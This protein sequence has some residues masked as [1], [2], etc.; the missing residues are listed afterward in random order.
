MISELD[1][2]K[3]VGTKKIELIDSEIEIV[4]GDAALNFHII[5]EFDDENSSYDFKNPPE[6]DDLDLLET[7]ESELLE[8]LMD[9]LMSEEEENEE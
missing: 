4:H 7:S 6:S 8:Y 9:F 2:I 5:E 1:S 3:I